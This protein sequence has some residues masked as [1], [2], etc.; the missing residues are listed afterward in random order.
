MSVKIEPLEDRIVVKAAAPESVTS[1]GLIIPDNARE[2][3]QEGTVIAV[4]PGRMENGERVTLGLVPG[5]TVIYSKFGG[6]EVRYGGDDFILLT[7]RDV[8]AKVTRET[9]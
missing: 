2:K 5:D 3:P 6:V 4:G 1:F 9:D 7:S 8:L